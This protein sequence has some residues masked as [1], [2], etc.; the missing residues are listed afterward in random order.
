MAFVVK[1]KQIQTADRRNATASG[2]GQN[3][4]MWIK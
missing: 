1:D 3:E 2:G 4:Y